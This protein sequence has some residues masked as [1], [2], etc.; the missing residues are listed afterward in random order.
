M[1]VV[2]MNKP[3]TYERQPFPLLAMFGHVHYYADSGADAVNPIRVVYAPSWQL[4]YSF[5][6]RIGRGMIP[7]EVGAV[8]IKCHAGAYELIPWLHTPR[9]AGAVRV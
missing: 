9:P 4:P 6:H 1:P 2:H 8:W 5:I 3:T 7:N